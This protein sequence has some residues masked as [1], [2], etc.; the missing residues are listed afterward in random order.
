MNQNKTGTIISSNRE[1]FSGQ[2]DLLC[3]LQT[4][5]QA[6]LGWAEDCPTQIDRNQN[7]CA[8]SR[9]A[10]LLCELNPLMSPGVRDKKKVH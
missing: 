10:N 6:P 5:K 8:P 2:E 9:D 7:I 1:T 4:K 3:N